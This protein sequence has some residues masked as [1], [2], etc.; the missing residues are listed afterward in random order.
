M[1][2]GGSGAP[3]ILADALDGHLASHRI[4]PHLLRVDDFDGFMAD[5]QA[6]L[7]KLIEAAMGKAAHQD[8]AGP[9][10]EAEAD[11]EAMEAGLVMEAAA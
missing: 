2:I 9:S 5:R 3:P 1:E 4:A 10:D 6:S 11:D 8:A 7:L